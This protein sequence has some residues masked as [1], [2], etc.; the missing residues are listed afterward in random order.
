MVLIIKC[1]EAMGPVLTICVVHVGQCTQAAGGASVG[2]GQGEGTVVSCSVCL[3]FLDYSGWIKPR[4]SRTGAYVCVCVCVCV[5][6]V[7]G[8]VCVFVCACVPCVCVCV[9]AVCVCAVGVCVCV[10]VHAFRVGAYVC[11][12][13]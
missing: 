1:I 2:T 13:V 12:C 6:V 5:C 10:C 8:C 3:L 11:V 7:R 4:R 9:R